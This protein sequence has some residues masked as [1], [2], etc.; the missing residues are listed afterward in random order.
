MTLGY[1]ESFPSNIHFVESFHSSLSSRKL[2]QRLM[3]VIGTINRKEF[4]F[5]EV[6][7]PTVSGGK[8]IFEFGLADGSGFNFIDE[9]EVKKTLEVLSGERLQ[10]LDFFCV[11]RYY[12]VSGE[13][14]KALKFDYYLLRTVYSK[15]ILEVQVSHERGPR[16]LSPEDLSMFIFGKINEA[17]S[18]KVLKRTNA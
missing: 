3:Q 7:N 13:K 11:V 6:A 17:A 1:Y 12:R 2:Q 8:V 9:A 18:R 10:A 5:E 15:D 4:S 14:R 16:Y